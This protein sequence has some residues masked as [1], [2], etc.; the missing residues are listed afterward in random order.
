MAMILNG[1][2]FGKGAVMCAGA[3]VTKDVECFSVV[4]GVPASEIYKRTT[5]LNYTINYG[6]LFT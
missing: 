5:A 1:V 2:Y 3:V 4:A 6:R